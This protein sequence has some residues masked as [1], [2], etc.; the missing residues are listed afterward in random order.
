MRERENGVIRGCPYEIRGRGEDWDRCSGGKGEKERIA[1][2]RGGKRRK[3][4]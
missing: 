3:V 1:W 4:T 2:C